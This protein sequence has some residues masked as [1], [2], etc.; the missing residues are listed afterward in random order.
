MERVVHLKRAPYD[1]R[2][3][4]ATRWGNP[5]T[6][7]EDVYQK[8]YTTL[9]ASREEAIEAYRNFLWREIKQYPDTIKELAALDG[10]V[11]GCWCKP[12]ACHGDVLV[13]AARWAVEELKKE[14]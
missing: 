2:I 1:V 6:H 8:G 4:R 10:K 14:A 7:R 11:L 13:R 5:Y 3:D 9:V 12:K